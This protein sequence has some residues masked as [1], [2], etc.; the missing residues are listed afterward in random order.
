MEIYPANTAKRVLISGSRHWNDFDQFEKHLLSLDFLRKRCILIGGEQKGVDSLVKP[1]CEKHKHFYVGCPL[2]N[3]EWGDFGGLAG[4]QR[5]QRMFIFGEPDYV[6]AFPGP[7]S[8]GTYNA[9]KQ[10]KVLGIEPVIF[11]VSR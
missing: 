9:I 10:G 4:P 2:L 3:W 7:D 6:V 11:H 8:V 5:N 1:F